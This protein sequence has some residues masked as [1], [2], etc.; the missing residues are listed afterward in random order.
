MTTIGNK[1]DDIER[2]EVNK[3]DHEELAAK[4]GAHIHMQVS[5][6]TGQNVDK[7]F[8]QIGLELLK[9]DNLH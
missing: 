7:M 5:A 1:S 3:K 2:A 4:V 9:R 8:E 6:K